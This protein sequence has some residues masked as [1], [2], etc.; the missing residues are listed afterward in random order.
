MRPAIPVATAP[1]LCRGLYPTMTNPRN[2]DDAV[3]T[4]CATLLLDEQFGA[5]DPLGEKIVLGWTQMVVYFQLPEGQ[6]A[7]S[8][9]Y[10]YRDQL[11]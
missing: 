8:G 4:S 7:N 1:R 5:D 2:R 9:W 10:P 6:K 3:A 11:S